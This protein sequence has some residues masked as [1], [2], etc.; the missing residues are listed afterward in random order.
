MKRIICILFLSVFLNNLH[1]QVDKIKEESDKNKNESENLGGGTGENDGGS[2]GGSP[3]ME[4][5]GEACFSGVTAFCFDLA[6]SGMIDLHKSYLKEKDDI[7]LVTSFDFI[8]QFGYHPPSSMVAMPRIRGNWGLFSTD[9]R[10]TSLIEITSN[11]T[12]FYNTIDWQIL[13]LNVLVTKPVILRIGSGLMYEI[14]SKKTFSEHSLGLDIFLEDFKYRI[15]N[16]FRIT[17]DYTT[18]NIPRIEGSTTFNY[19][20]LQSDNIDAYVLLGVLYQNYYLYVPV[21]SC[22]GGMAFNFH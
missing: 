9:A 7:P 4:S 21:W 2:N 16:E 22:L 20:V 10:F 17:P 19:A 8:P 6:I 5:C 13:Q 3:C 18:G 11:G 14:Y 15:N 12:D 1:A